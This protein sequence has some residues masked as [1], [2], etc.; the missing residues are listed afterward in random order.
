MCLSPA[1]TGLDIH[2]CLVNTGLALKNHRQHLMCN[3]RTSGRDVVKKV[4]LENPFNPRLRLALLEYHS[5]RMLHNPPGSSP[6]E[7]AMAQNNIPARI[8][9]GNWCVLHEHSRKGFAASS[10]RNLIKS[11]LPMV[12]FSPGRRDKPGYVCTSIFM[13]PALFRK[14]TGKSLLS[15]GRTQLLSLVPGHVRLTME[16]KCNPRTADPRRIDTTA[17]CVT[18]PERDNTGLHRRTSSLLR[19]HRTPAAT[20]FASPSGYAGCHLADDW[21]TAMADGALTRPKTQRHMDCRRRENSPLCRA[22]GRHTP[23]APLTLQ[24]YAHQR[25]QG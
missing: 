15:A 19:K 12:Q 17:A 21:V 6:G 16:A 24:R 13:R 4:A 10:T 11:H 2:S 8:Y 22:D 25:E 18:F 14:S 3:S 23:A 5:G 9:P 20:V 1:N 7:H